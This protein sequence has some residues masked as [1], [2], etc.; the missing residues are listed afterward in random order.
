MS[1]TK[2]LPL[3]AA[4]YVMSLPAVRAQDLCPSGPLETDPR[5]IAAAIAAQPLNLR[6]WHEDRLYRPT[7][8]LDSENSGGLMSYTDHRLT[9]DAKRYVVINADGVSPG[10]PRLHP[11]HSAGV[12]RLLSNQVIRKVNRTTYTYTIARPTPKQ[13][14][15]FA[16]LLNRMVGPT[17][18]KN[19]PAPTQPEA[20]STW[21]LK[22]IP[23]VQP[24]EPC[25]STTFYA[26]QGSDEYE[27]YFMLMSQGGELKYD[28]E[29]PCVTRYELLSR[30]KELV[31]DMLA[32]STA[33]AD[34]T[35]QPPYVR[36]VATDASDNL[37]L[38]LAPGT[39]KHPAAEI[40]EVTPSG[41]SIH[42][43]APVE[44][45]VDSGAFIIDRGGHV[46]LGAGPFAYDVVPDIDLADASWDSA[47]ARTVA[48]HTPIDSI[49]RDASDHLYA[50][51]GPGIL[52]FTLAGDLT[53]FADLPRSP[54]QPAS[55]RPC[56]VV[57]TADGTLYVAD[58]SSN[59]IF[60]VTQG[61]AVIL[62]AGTPGKSGATDG[63][64]NK[65]RF[66]SPQ[67]IALDRNGTIYVADSGNQTI[68]RISP[69]GLVS[70]LAGKPG[71][72]GTADGRGTSARFDHPISIAVDSTG[73]VYVTNGQD[74]LIRKISPEGV[75]STLNA[76][77]L[78]DAP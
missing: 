52:R 25:S 19:P 31:G 65:A 34:G 11:P 63:P 58:S 23:T 21:S 41:D 36:S 78:I 75:V 61:K 1:L 54:E 16:C 59:A 6:T 48:L 27:S 3:I 72:R 73:T 26:E 18:P 64:G 50:T 7:D 10:G 66:K 9:Y 24:A 12:T 17:H 22:D 15:R 47:N 74:S 76:R 43:T 69:D 49:T 38:L 29:L 14:R 37:Y 70:T 40:L 4:A 44:E 56:Y 32:E 71:R 51:S 46:Q 28:P 35:W 60:E 67:G 2:I 45:S 20:H 77:Q 53:S 55:H 68:R 42:L 8:G 39:I 62:F 33:H 30:V 13:A 57:A 5:V